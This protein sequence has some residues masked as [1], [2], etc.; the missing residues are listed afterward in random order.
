M[1]YENQKNGLV[2]TDVSA[3]GAVMI[4]A[5]SPVRG[6]IR[7]L[8]HYT[9]P[10]P[11]LVLAL[12]E[13]KGIWYRFYANL[14]DTDPLPG[15]NKTLSILNT[16]ERIGLEVNRTSEN[17]SL[18]NLPG[19]VAFFLKGRMLDLPRGFRTVWKTRPLTP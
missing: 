1:P 7:R 14:V 15:L 9:E 12:G 4:A 2:A 18:P 11:Y 16:T 19:V 8:E 5:G 6:R 17:L 10:F 3:K 13:L